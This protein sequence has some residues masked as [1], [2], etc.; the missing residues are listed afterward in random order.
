MGMQGQSSSGFGRPWLIPSVEF[1]YRDVAPPAPAPPSRWG[2]GDITAVT[3]QIIVG[4][5]GY[6][7]YRLIALLSSGATNVFAIFGSA[8]SPISIPAAYQTDAPF[9]ANIGGVSPTIYESSPVAASDSWLTVGLTEGDDQSVLSAVGLDFDSWTETAA[10]TSADGAV[11]WLNPSNG[12][13]GTV[14]VAQLTVPSGSSG[15]VTMGMQ[16]QSTSGVG[17]PWIKHGVTFSYGG[18][19]VVPSGVDGAANTAALSCPWIETPLSVT[20]H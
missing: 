13:S 3:E 18:S 15:I 7:T 11:F 12:P 16:G 10:L 4:E 8:V 20:R 2:D 19:S 6:S 1:S 5:N 17:D 14:T 9:G